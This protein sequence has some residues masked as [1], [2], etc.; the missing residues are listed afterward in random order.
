M[1]S[2]N[3]TPEQEQF[4]RDNAAGVTNVVLTEKLNKCFGTHF[5]SK[6]VKCYK[7]KHHIKSGIKS[8]SH[9]IGTERINHGYILIKI[10][11]PNV[12][13]EK[14]RVVYESVYGTIPK[15]HKLM[16]LDGNKQNCSIEN[17]RLIKDYEEAYLNKMGYT[18][19]SKEFT[20]AAINL[21]KLKSKIKEM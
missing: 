15:G 9:K 3:F 5:E 20:E 16:F 2:R 13:K 18:G 11:E 1:S 21:V 17:L 7:E 8:F 14:H 19:I 10:D 12:W 4:I 6:T